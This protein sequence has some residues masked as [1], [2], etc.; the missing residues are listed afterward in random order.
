[1]PCY[2]YYF[3]PLASHHFFFLLHCFLPNIHSSNTFSPF[4]III[5]SITTLSF[6]SPSLWAETTLTVLLLMRARVRLWL[7]RWDDIMSHNLSFTSQ[8]ARAGRRLTHQSLCRRTEEFNNLLQPSG[9]VA[10]GR[11]IAT[12]VW[13]A[14][15]GYLGVNSTTL[16][17]RS[18]VKCTQSEHIQTV[19]KNVCDVPSVYGSVRG[20]VAALRSVQPAKH[21]PLLHHNS[22]QWKHN[23]QWLITSEL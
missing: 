3:H 13:C 7:H 9:F 18:L 20:L 1:M 8:R 12:G 2:C 22:A 11:A 6:F 23:Q 5:F 21:N 16:S 4:I 17:Q 14:R 19:L 15:A 10:E